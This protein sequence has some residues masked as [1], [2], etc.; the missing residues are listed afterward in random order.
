M[1]T[2]ENVILFLDAKVIIRVLAFVSATACTNVTHFHFLDELQQNQKL[3][4]CVFISHVN[5]TESWN[6]DEILLLLL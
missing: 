3:V 1:E 6:V 2:V 4:L 5:L